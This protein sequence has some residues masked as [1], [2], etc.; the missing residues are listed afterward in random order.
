MKTWGIYTWEFWTRFEVAEFAR[1]EDAE[2]A[3]RYLKEKYGGEYELV[4]ERV[5]E[6]FGEFLG[7]SGISKE[8]INGKGGR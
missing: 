7:Y 6:S 8:S 3:L 5:F 4:P 1:K 2:K